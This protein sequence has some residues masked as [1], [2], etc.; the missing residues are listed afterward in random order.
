MTVP[1]TIR[2]ANRLATNEDRTV[3]LEGLALDVAGRAC[4]HLDRTDAI[5]PVAGFSGWDESYRE[6]PVRGRGVLSR[7]AKANDPVTGIASL[8]L[9]GATVELLP[10]PSDD[11]IRTAP[12]MRASEGSE[13][14]IEGM[15]Y[16]SSNGPILVLYGGLAYVRDLPDWDDETVTR[17]VVVLGTIRHPPL[18]PD[19][20]EAGGSWAI[21]GRQAR[22]AHELFE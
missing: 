15:A 14:E 8:A 20:P 19:A 2:T 18:P 11:R 4:I 1:E 10:Q 9:A 22:L 13:V 16:R 21:E 6:R 5:V 7:H 3:V 12:A 17:T